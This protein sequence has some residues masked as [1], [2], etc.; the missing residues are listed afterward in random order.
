M[1]KKA[2]SAISTRTG[3]IGVL[4]ETAAL[5]I[6]RTNCY[7]LHMSTKPFDT[8]DGKCKLSL[9]LGNPL[10]ELMAPKSARKSPSYQRDNPRDYTL[11]LRNPEACID[12]LHCLARK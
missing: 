12:Y 6:P 10:Q 7:D 4:E 3:S 1:S 5:S 11:R 2:I 8:D 9:D